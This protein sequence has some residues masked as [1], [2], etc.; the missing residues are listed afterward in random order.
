MTDSAESKLVRDKLEMI[1]EKREMTEGEAVDAILMSSLIDTRYP[2]LSDEERV[3]M[4]GRPPQGRT[5]DVETC[6][7]LYEEVLEELPP[8]PWRMDS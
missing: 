4:L 7:A 8:P 6:K 3:A 1:R 2:N 5:F